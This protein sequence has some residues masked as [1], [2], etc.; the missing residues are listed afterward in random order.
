MKCALRLVAV[1]VFGFASFPAHA[2]DAMVNLPKRD[3]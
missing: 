2:D 1:I 3:R